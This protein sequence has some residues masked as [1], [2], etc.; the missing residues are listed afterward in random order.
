MKYLL[1]VLACLA[2]MFGCKKDDN[3]DDNSNGNTGKN[4]VFITEDVTASTTWYADSLY[5]IKA[6]DFYV[7]NSL[8]IQ[9]GTIIK[10]HPADGPYMV[11][12][13][14]GTIIARGT[15]SNPIIFTSLKDDENGGDTND[16]GA[17]TTPA[18]KDWGYISTNSY[19]GCI[20]EYCKFL[21]G[22]DGWYSATLYIDTESIATVENC[23]FAHNDGSDSKGWYGA[24]DASTAGAGTIISDNTFYDNI[25]PMSVS[26]VFNVDN[27]NVFH[28]PDNPSET[29]RYNGVFVTSLEEI[30][31]A[32]SW[33]ETEVAYVIDD[34]DF[35][36]NE[37]AT[38]T[39][40][41]NVVLKFRADG[42]LVLNDGESAIVNHDGTGV[43]FT[44]YKD[45]T[46][47]GDTNGDGSATTSNNT[48]WD[49]IYD[50]SMTIPS[51]YYYTWS[52]ILYDSY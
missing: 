48:D 36:I 52:N 12:G 45:D 18:R 1:V 2:V 37:A 38:L 22:G 8:T 33:S 41:D 10:F 4:I 34:N 21:Y 26:T 44:S 20:F 14:G 13:S 27:S 9:A 29:N 30:N 5:V 24:L 3:D 39:L 46:H 32:I 35:W 47:K 6:Y 7:L 28:N 51:P 16:D 17:A 40:A 43:Y 25:R 23:T 15:A 42:T 49:G 11:M 50:N 31:T 19:N